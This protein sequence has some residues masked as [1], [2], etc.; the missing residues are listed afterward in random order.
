MKVNV[1]TRVHY[2]TMVLLGL[3]ARTVYSMY[4]IVER[5]TLDGR[6]EAP[7]PSRSVPVGHVT[8]GGGRQLH[9]PG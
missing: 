1:W 5:S 2:I 3:D 4:L 8:G 7:A 9:H 6:C